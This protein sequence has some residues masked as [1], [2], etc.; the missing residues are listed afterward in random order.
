MKIDTKTKNGNTITIEINE[1]GSI[2]C[3]VVHPKF[4]EISGVG[5]WGKLQGREGVTVK[6][7][8]GEKWNN[9]LFEIN[10]DVFAPFELERD[11]IEADKKKAEKLRDQLIK[12]EALEMCPKDCVIAQ[13]LWSNGD[14]CAAEYQDENGTKALA[15]DLLDHHFEWYFVEKR[16]FDEANEIK[17]KKQAKEQADKKA[18]EKRV[19][20]I[21]ARAKSTGEKQEL[22]RFSI[23]CQDPHEECSV[24]IVTVWAMPDGSKTETLNHTW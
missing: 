10:R 12:N 22:K 17:E 6:A 19:A 5:Q 3:K 24:D 8:V 16:H 4:G 21:F 14:L 18:E 9:C 7:F 2:I 11:N 20:E 1:C 13:Q 23:E 15:S